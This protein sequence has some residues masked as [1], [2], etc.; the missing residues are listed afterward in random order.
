[1]DDTTVEERFEFNRA[2]MM[3]KCLHNLAPSYLQTDLIH[4][5]E[6]HDH[7]TRLTTSN[8]VCRNFK[9]TVINTVLLYLPYVLGIILTA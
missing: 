2:V 8:N 1:M 9:Q 5:S 7:F 6:I 3:Y 4:P